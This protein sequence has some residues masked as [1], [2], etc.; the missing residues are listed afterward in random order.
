MMYMI[1]WFNYNVMDVRNVVMFYL[2]SIADTT[3]EFLPADNTDLL[4]FLIAATLR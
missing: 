1:L 3:N 4:N 2:V